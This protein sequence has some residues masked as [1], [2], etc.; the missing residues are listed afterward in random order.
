VDMTDVDSRVLRPQSSRH[1]SMNDYRPRAARFVT[2]SRARRHT[3]LNAELAE[4]AEQ[5]FLRVLRSLR[6]SL[7]LKAA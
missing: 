3:T 6:C 4:Q 5:M 7:S 1:L 2:F